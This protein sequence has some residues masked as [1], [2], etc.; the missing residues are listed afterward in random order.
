MRTKGV[1]VLRC[2]GGDDFGEH[3]A[4]EGDVLRV[5]RASAVWNAVKS[6]EVTHKDDLTGSPRSY[7]REDVCL[8]YGEPK[9]RRY[10]SASPRQARSSRR[11]TMLTVEG[12]ASG[13]SKSVFRR[14]AS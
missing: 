11:P 5:R 4:W 9:G 3:E 12:E 14:R 13:R 8:G 2:E 10:D 7:L 6:R 1:D